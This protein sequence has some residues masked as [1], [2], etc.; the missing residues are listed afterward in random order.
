M[1]ASD[2]SGLEAFFQAVHPA[3]VRYAERFVPPD[4]ASDIVQD[5]F[6]RLWESR[7][8]I[9]PDRSLKAM[10]YS[11]VRNLCLNRIRDGQTRAELLAERSAYDG[12]TLVG[13][14]ESEVL[15]RDFATQLEE[16]I[17]ELPDRQ[18]EALRLSRFE[19]LSHREVAEAMDVSERTVNNHLVKALRTM[20][21]RIRA[22]DPTL[23][24]S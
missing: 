1:R 6:V 11:T 20:R 4:T 22:Y 17:D 19:G 15:G 2:V 16:W 3:L 13:S 21:D 18:K 8:R 5:A 9:D 7:E 12:P 10:A 14:P 24:D 23:L